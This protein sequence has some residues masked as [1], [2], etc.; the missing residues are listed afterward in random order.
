[1]RKFPEPQ[2][3]LKPASLLRRLAAILYDS[4]L[5]A[6]LWM[7]LGGIGVAINRGEAVSGP[8]FSSTL[9][10]VTF[11]FFAGFWTRNGQTLGMQAWRIRVQT[12]EGCAIT[13]MQAL[14]RFF[15]AMASAVCFGLG[16]WWMLFDK[17][18]LTWQDRY[19]E[20][21]VVLLPSRKKTG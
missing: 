18:Q 12:P 10:L 4:L 14:L 16:Y 5:V 11:L 21:R 20:S 13:L 3:T 7:V 17:Q 9:F 6:A 2:N 1:M 19:S 8:L 15:T